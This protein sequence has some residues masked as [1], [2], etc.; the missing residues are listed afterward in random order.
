MLCS[1]QSVVLSSELRLNRSL[2]RADL[3]SK[4]LRSYDGYFI[5]NSLVCLEVEGELGIVSFD[6]DFCR[7]LDRLEMLNQIQ[8]QI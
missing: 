5:A 3:V 8:T 6:D 4:T 1:Q 2:R 7:L